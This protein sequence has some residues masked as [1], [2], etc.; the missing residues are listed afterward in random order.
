MVRK[1]Y[2]V[3]S[4]HLFASRIWTLPGSAF[5]FAKMPAKEAA[6]LIW[7]PVFKPRGMLM[8]TVVAAPGSLPT[9]PATTIKRTNNRV[10]M[11][12]VGVVDRP[13]HQSKMQNKLLTGFG[14]H[15]FWGVM[16]SSGGLL[17]KV[18]YFGPAPLIASCASR[19]GD[20]MHWPMVDDF[21]RSPD[22]PRPP[23]PDCTMTIMNAPG[24]PREKSTNRRTFKVSRAL[25]RLTLE[26][27]I[28]NAY[29]T[30]FAVGSQSSVCI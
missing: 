7:L 30:Y 1:R 12:F 8:H 3:T 2:H 23:H 16:G 29:S 11:F 24:A 22:P 26:G 4:I 28:H 10:F 21:P 18:H 20:G 19:R 25:G 13:R 6:F 5:A 27:F 9:G 14:N 15:R 17:T